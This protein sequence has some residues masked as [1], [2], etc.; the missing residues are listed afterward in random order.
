MWYIS[1][2]DI[3]NKIDP[4]PVYKGCRATLCACLG[5]CK[6]VI[7]SI[8]FEKYEEFQ[9][10]KE[11]ARELELEYITAEENYRDY[12]REMRKDFPSIIY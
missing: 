10:K 11:K 8:P 9:I 7:G 2:Q 6:K 5:T 3:E 1:K 12:L 4:L